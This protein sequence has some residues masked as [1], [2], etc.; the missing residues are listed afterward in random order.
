MAGYS[1]TPLLRKLGVREGSRVAL[2]HAPPDFASSWGALPVGAQLVPAARAATDVIVLFATTH[3][4]L[5]ADLA[6]AMAALAPTGGLWL[7]W[8]NGRARGPP[9]PTGATPPAAGP[10]AGVGGKKGCALHASW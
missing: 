4:Q 2:L 1:G 7:P 8:P 6:C 3:V 5:S 9:D 10:G